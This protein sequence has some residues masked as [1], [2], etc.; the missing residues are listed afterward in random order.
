MLHQVL[1]L[2]I[3]SESSWPLLFLFSKTSLDFSKEIS[4][5]VQTLN[6][7]CILVF[8]KKKKEVNSKV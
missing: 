6:Q 5:A 4:R 2:F 1:N 8:K 7:E 3:F